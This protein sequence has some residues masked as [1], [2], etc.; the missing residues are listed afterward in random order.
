[1]TAD[2]LALPLQGPLDGLVSFE[3]VA[4]MH[5]VS[6]ITR[7]CRGGMKIGLAVNGMD[8]RNPQ[9][10]TA[11]GLLLQHGM[12]FGMSERTPLKKRGTFTACV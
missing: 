1:M 12:L 11:Q 10:R 3:F 9:V 2:G 7:Y 4:V 8:K 6:M 5:S